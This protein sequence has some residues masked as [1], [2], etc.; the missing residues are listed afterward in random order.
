M[1]IFRLAG[2]MTHLLSIIVLL[3]KIRATRSCKGRRWSA[4][5]AFAEQD[6]P[7]LPPHGP[8]WD[9][10]PPRRHLQ[11]DAGAVPARVCH[12]IPGS[13]LLLHLPVGWCG[14]SVGGWARGHCLTQRQAALTPSPPPSPCHQVQHL[15]EDH[16]P[17]FLLRHCVLHA[18]RPG[19][20]LDL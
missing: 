10:S 2:D 15:Y 1:N 17:R 16:L 8:A 13:V 3:L 12:A 14:L 4:H 5:R 7:G 19:H 18:V 6:H 9:T 11:E 20:L